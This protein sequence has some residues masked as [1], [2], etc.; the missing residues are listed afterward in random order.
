MAYITVSADVDVDLEEFETDELLEELEKRGMDY[1]SKYV[2]PDHMRKLLETIWLKR[3]NGNV[4]YQLELD[5][6]IYGILG[7]IV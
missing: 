4:D 7:K 1:N 5:Q 3:R 6:L 2:D